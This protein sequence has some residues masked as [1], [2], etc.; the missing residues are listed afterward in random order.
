MIN[1]IHLER[2]GLGG[3]RCNGTEALIE[4]SKHSQH[5]NEKQLWEQLHTSG[6]EGELVFGVC[7]CKD[8]RPPSLNL[9]QASKGEIQREGEE[10]G[11]AEGERDK[12]ARR[13]GSS[14]AILW[15]QWCQTF[16]LEGHVA[17]V[18]HSGHASSRWGRRG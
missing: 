2:G 13:R 17:S 5:V 16:Y 1:Q 6:E 10:D 12:D 14:V 18:C 8:T 4:I 11:A 3:H 15:Y 9:G 7:R